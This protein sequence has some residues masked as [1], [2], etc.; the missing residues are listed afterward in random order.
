MAAE[1]EGVTRFT[2][3]FL[4]SEWTH[5]VDAWQV[6]DEAAYAGVPRMGRRTRLGAKQRAE[7]WPVFARAAGARNARA[8]DRPRC[9]RR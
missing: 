2:E 7:V 3:Q 5:V 8:D 6:A 4:V 9:S 1:A